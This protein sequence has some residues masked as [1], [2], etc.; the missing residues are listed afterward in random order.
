MEAQAGEPGTATL[1]TKPLLGSSA[2]CP[3]GATAWF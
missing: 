2:H 1:P 3:V